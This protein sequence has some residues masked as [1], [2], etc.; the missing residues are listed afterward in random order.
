VRSHPGERTRRRGGPR[1]RHTFGRR[2]A[3]ERGGGRSGCGEQERNALGLGQ[4]AHRG[5]VLI[6]RNPR[7]T[8]GSDPTATDRSRARG[9][10]TAQAGSDFPGPGPGC[11]LVRGSALPR[12]RFRVGPGQVWPFWAP[13]W[14]GLG[15]VHSEFWLF[16]Q[17]HI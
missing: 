17:K 9:P 14:T 3:E 13:F 10:L 6:H 8:V 2:R 7:V 5:W 4:H 11:G 1:R 15:R 12:A 16:S